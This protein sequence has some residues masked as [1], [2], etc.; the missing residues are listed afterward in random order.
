MN[1]DFL[2]KCTIL[3]S[4]TERVSRA[5][6]SAPSER[7]PQL[8]CTASTDIYR[9]ELFTDTFNS[10]AHDRGVFVKMAS[11]S[12]FSCIVGKIPHICLCKCQ[13]LPFLLKSSSDVGAHC[14]TLSRK[15]NAS[16]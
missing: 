4:F 7:Q 2:Q 9:E 13:P 15:V 16:R 6:H 8:V 3:T 5:A 12:Q 11:D 14:V 10:I 1:S